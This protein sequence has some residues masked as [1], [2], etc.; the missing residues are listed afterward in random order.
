[1]EQSSDTGE[2]YHP[3]YQVRCLCEL[4][5]RTLR[6]KVG[7]RA[8]A[9]HAVGANKLCCAVSGN[10]RV[11]LCVFWLEPGE[12]S[13]VLLCYYICYRTCRVQRLAVLVV[14]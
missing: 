5:I 6:L 14:G 12:G 9:L 7:C 11:G 8:R 3:C 1:M 10:A 4:D 13:V 2:G